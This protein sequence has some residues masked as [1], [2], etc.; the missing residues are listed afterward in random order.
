MEG[1]VAHPVVVDPVEE[2]SH[3]YMAAAAVY[4]DE[5][6]L[7][8]DR[9]HEA[10][11]DLDRWVLTLSGG[12]L[13]LSMTL[14]GVLLGAGW[15]FSVAWISIAWL[16]FAGS[17]SIVVFSVWAS[18]KG[19]EEYRE[20]LDRAF[21]KNSADW[22]SIAIE[23]QNRSRWPRW[24]D[25]A[26][27]FSTSLFALGILCLVVFVTTI[28]GAEKRLLDEQERWNEGV[29]ASSASATSE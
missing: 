11:R 10:H 1:S 29:E 17:V 12:A 23:L 4:R 27:L 13:G 5:R 6:K 16:L 26:N 22:Q 28:S 2:D 15:K 18:A 9:S 3:V 20:C 8:V 25:R 24:I 7:L 21:S 14:L 19:Y